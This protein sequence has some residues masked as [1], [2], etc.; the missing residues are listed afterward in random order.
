MDTKKTCKLDVDCFRQTVVEKLAIMV[1]SKVEDT[2]HHLRI[3]GKQDECGEVELAFRKAGHGYAAL[4]NGKHVRLVYVENEA[5]AWTV[6]GEM[7]AR[8]AEERQRLERL[9]QQR[10]DTEK[11]LL[12]LKGFPFPED[13][14]CRCNVRDGKAHLEIRASFGPER[15]KAFFDMV[16]MAR[17]TLE[18]C[19][20]ATPAEDD[21]ET[22]REG[23]VEA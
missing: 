16:E 18:D 15:I 7:M 1:G 10:S 6:A 3:A 23:T 14:K 8:L 21:D 5:N 20:M 11:C 4:V 2:G 13:G 19:D 17:L 9:R 22:V 12:L